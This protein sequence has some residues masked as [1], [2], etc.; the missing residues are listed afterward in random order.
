MMTRFLLLFLVFTQCTAL[1]AQEEHCDQYL[2]FAVRGD[3][4]QSIDP[5]GAVAIWQEARRVLDPASCP[6]GYFQAGVKLAERIYYA[7]Q[8][9]EAMETFES[10]IADQPGQLQASSICKGLLTQ[11]LF[12]EEMGKAAQA[13]EYYQEAIALIRSDTTQGLLLGT[14]YLNLG[15]L[16][17]FQGQLDS[18]AL[19]FEEALQVPDYQANKAYSLNAYSNLA[20]IY[21]MQGDNQRALD[22]ARYSLLAKEQLFPPVHNSIAYGYINLSTILTST[23]Q[24]AQAARCDSVAI[25][26]RE[27]LYS[28]PHQMLAEAYIS[29]ANSLHGIGRFGASLLQYQKS[30]AQLE[31]IEVK[32]VRL[33]FTYQF[34]ADVLIKLGR[35]AEAREYLRKAE[36]HTEQY[37]LSSI[38]LEGGLMLSKA[39]ALAAEGA[40]EPALQLLQEAQ[41]LVCPDYDVLRQPCAEQALLFDMIAFRM[42]VLLQRAMAEPQTDLQ[43]EIAR[44]DQQVDAIIL[45]SEGQQSRR[46]L[47]EGFMPVYELLV[48]YYVQQGD[49]R[50]AIRTVELSKAKVQKKERIEQLVRGRHLLWHEYNSRRQQVA[51]QIGSLQSRITEANDSSGID[52]LDS[53]HRL[54]ARST[55]LFTKLRGLISDPTWVA[56]DSIEVQGP[57]L[58]T[59]A[60]DAV[61]H[62]FYLRPDTLVY[63]TLPRE[64]TDTRVMAL[65]QVLQNPF[66]DNWQEHAQELSDLFDWSLLLQEADHT[67]RIIPDGSLWQ[68][69]FDVLPLPAQDQASSQLLIEQIALNYQTHLASTPPVAV[70]PGAALLAC[71][72]QGDSSSGQGVLQGSMEELKALQV[73]EG[74][75]LP[76]PDESRFKALA[77][78]YDIIHLAVHGIIDS[79]SGNHHLQ[80]SGSGKQEDGRLHTYE[81]G[82]LDL[83][84]SLAVLSACNTGV[85]A[86]NR[87]EANWSLGTAFAY[88]GVPALT[89]SRWSIEDQA[90]A[91][92]MSAYYQALATGVTKSEALRQAKR[93]YLQEAVPARKHPY[94]WAGLLSMGD[95]QPLQ[96]QTKSQGYYPYILVFV[97]L[98]ALLLWRGFRRKAQLQ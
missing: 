94:Y 59:M 73:Y 87:G 75:I 63:R 85:G 23:G 54:Q 46:F 11:A 3:S 33:A 60:G 28:S 47:L 31:Q 56:I 27:Q 40:W 50:S 92:L 74:L 34:T 70:S 41:A 89:L 71:G 57:V 51:Q 69:N 93:S 55:A 1:R 95:D 36:A 15:V 45:S 53:L 61:Y 58:Y 18:A 82:N 5:A 30:I 79:L 9:E 80:F 76:G 38:T 83:Q 10:V 29:L 43:T 52:A 32:T 67:L 19:A 96:L 22:Y 90:T 14:T 37:Q 2:D 8:L 64:E 44:F 7:G 25:E 26:I 24:Y 91:T 17:Y 6:D 62:L 13:R 21:N 48:S 39:R 20:A 81:I 68:L 4:L 35:V 65:N 12:A 84:A 42:Q 97:L 98:L 77:G 66:S 16:F 49:L 78:D 88:A 86:G 72:Y